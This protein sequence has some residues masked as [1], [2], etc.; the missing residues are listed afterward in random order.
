M[1]VFETGFF[2]V[3]LAVSVDQAGLKM[4]DLPASAS[5][6]RSARIKGGATSAWPVLA[7]L[8][9]FFETRSHSLILTGCSGNHCVDQAGLC[10]FSSGIEGAHYQHLA[11]C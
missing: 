10:L 4:R 5:A 11:E 9:C 1:F 7:I 2:C 3:T 8:F 6:W